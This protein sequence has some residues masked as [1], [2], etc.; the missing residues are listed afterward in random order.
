MLITKAED[1]SHAGWGLRWWCSLHWTVSATGPGPSAQTA[2][3]TRGMMQNQQVQQD[4]KQTEHFTN[5]RLVENVGEERDWAKAVRQRGR[6]WSWWWGARGHHWIAFLLH[7]CVLKGIST[8]PQLRAERDQHPTIV[9][10]WKDEHPITKHTKEDNKRRDMHE[11]F[12]Q[13]GPGSLSCATQQC[14]YSHKT[15][16]QP[17]QGQG[18]NNGRGGGGGRR[19]TSWFICPKL[20]TAVWKS[21][22]VWRSP[23][24]PHYRR[25][26]GPATGLW[27]QEG[28]LND[29]RHT[30]YCGHNTT[31]QAVFTHLSVR[32][33]K[34]LFLSS[35]NYKINKGD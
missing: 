25:W 3:K 26:T 20:D 5:A 34:V 22:K 9:V 11:W 13:G 12:P 16:Q 15:K 14:S 30:A 7:S 27:P 2:H 24:R 10:C 18:D 31:Q 28:Q 29:C 1:Q 8:P 33:G 23:N 17:P 21:F 4:S 35:S 6:D 19:P 32:A